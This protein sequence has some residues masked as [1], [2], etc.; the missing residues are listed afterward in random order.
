MVTDI[1]FESNPDNNSAL[2]V[3]TAQSVEFVD[4][5]II[6]RGVSLST[7]Y[8]SNRSQRIVG[9]IGTQ[10]L[11]D[12]WRNEHS[13]FS[14]KPPAAA[15]SFVNPDPGAVDDVVIRID[16]PEL[17]EQEL[18]YSASI[19]E[20]HLYRLNGPCTLFIDAL[21]RPVSPVSFTASL[22]LTRDRSR[23]MSHDRRDVRDPMM[24]T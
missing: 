1:L 18:V 12:C 6:M 19:L 4:G 2:L 13:R 24:L 8:L 17:T 22:R 7:L 23:W 15:L 16:S 9:H 10:E 20:G 11:V 14:T 21:G 3:Q 5:H